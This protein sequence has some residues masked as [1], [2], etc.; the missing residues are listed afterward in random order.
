MTL[1]PKQFSL[2]H[3]TGGEVKG[4]VVDPSYSFD[5][6]PDNPGSGGAFATSKREVAGRAARRRAEREGRLFGV[7]YQVGLMTKDLKPT[8]YGDTEEYKDPKG[9]Q[10]IAPVDYPINTSAVE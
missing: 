8:E 6:D 9:L 2:Y 10:V 5:Y 7:V 3:G 4:G 1:N